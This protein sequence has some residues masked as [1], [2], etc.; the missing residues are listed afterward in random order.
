MSLLIDKD[1]TGIWVSSEQRIRQLQ[2]HMEYTAYCLDR[3]Y[4]T[5]QGRQ[6]IDLLNG[7]NHPIFI[8]PS[9]PSQGNNVQVLGMEAGESLCKITLMLLQ[10][11]PQLDTN[12]LIQMIN[13]KFQGNNL[14]TKLAE[15]AQ[16][17]N[18]MPLYSQFIEESQFPQVFLGQHLKYNGSPIDGKV[19][20][21]W[22]QKLDG[23]QFCDFLQ[24]DTVTVDGVRLVRYFRLAMIIELYNVSQR[25]KGAPS[26]VG[27]KTFLNNTDKDDLDLSRPPEVGLAHELIHALHNAN[28]SQPG[29]EYGN[30]ST[31]LAELIC[32]GLGPFVNEPITENT[33]RQGWDAFYGKVLV[34]RRKVYELAKDNQE[35]LQ[36]RQS[37]STY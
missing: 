32:V 11:L 35:I 3:I 37:S 16:N 30:F 19:L 24:N 12:E 2:R 7:S 13:Q 27:F 22:L 1:G 14:E 25:G 8:V 28:G 23:G 15:L 6:L 21:D 29:Q 36:F 4:L 18:S 17:I 33:I 9:S 10:P 31:L 5:N 20:Y 26:K 34:G